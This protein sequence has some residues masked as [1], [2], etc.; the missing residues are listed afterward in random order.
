MK[1]MIRTLC[2][3]LTVAA[4][5]ALTVC[6]AIAADKTMQGVF[7]DDL[8]WRFTPDDGTL[9]IEGKGE[10]PSCLC[11]E[12]DFY[13]TSTPW[14]VREISDSIRRVDVREG[15]T[16]IGSALFECC[17]ALQE[18]RLPRT[19]RSIGSSAFRRTALTDVRIPAG[20]EYI[21][22]DAFA[23]CENLRSVKFAA[24]QCVEIGEDAFSRT[25]FLNEAQNYDANGLLI[26]RGHLIN[27]KKDLRGVCTVPQGVT[28]IAAYAFSTYEEFGHGDA[29]GITE[30]VFPRSLEYIG[31]C[32]FIG[33]DQLAQIQ[34]LPENTRF[35]WSPFEET[36][37]PESDVEKYSCVCD[38]ETSSA[39]TVLQ[40]GPKDDDYAMH[41]YQKT[42]PDSYGVT[43]VL[44]SY[45]V[46]LL[47]PYFKD[48]DGVLYS[49]DGRV[50]LRYPG[51]RKDDTF[52]VP[53]G[54]RVIGA[55]AF[56]RYGSDE[57]TGLRKVILPE[58]V[59]VIRECAFDGC[60]NLEE[61][62]LPSTLKT[63]DA[64]AFSTTAI[65][66]MDLPDGLQDIGECFLSGSKITH[67][68]IPG[69][70]ESI[71]GGAFCGSLLESIRGYDR[72]P[73]TLEY[74]METSNFGGTPYRRTL[75][76]ETEPVVTEAAAKAQT[77]LP[78]KTEKP[79]DEPAAQPKYSM[80]FCTS[81]GEPLT[82]MYV[83]V[84]LFSRYRKTKLRLHYRKSISRRHSTEWSSDQEEV[85]VN[86]DDYVENRLH[87]AKAVTVTLSAKD[88]DG[89]VLAESHIR[90][91]YYRFNFQLRRMLKQSAQIE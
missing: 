11:W 20:V 21:G 18:V 68:R 23:D 40:I 10:T 62:V 52:T 47:N 77:E 59:T 41:S 8:T 67:I 58:G 29:A 1:K 61:V 81:D 45:S 49:R 65:T 69:S 89:N 57:Q 12:G 25:P 79:A 76:D 70:V 55:R 26:V 85:T 63:I 27:A 24:R 35:G 22:S 7:G 39:P 43:D 54:V 30:I 33:C 44:Q 42:D 90:V 19:L 73:Y 91:Y 75:N 15:V 80:Y 38:S 83:K 2:C 53:D 31:T 3:F 74:G 60:D 16:C 71:R 82:E 48:V 46:S 37:L 72:V 87:R 34:G 17:T 6:P 32:A 56:Q 13:A 9:T 84:G 88:T 50:L 28:D 51:G 86:A 4:T 14:H 36:A 5:L 64:C 78:A 66:H